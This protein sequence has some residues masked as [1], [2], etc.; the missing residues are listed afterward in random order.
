[1]KAFDKK[2]GKSARVNTEGD[3]KEDVRK[4]R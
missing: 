4:R 1:L 3:K 2:L